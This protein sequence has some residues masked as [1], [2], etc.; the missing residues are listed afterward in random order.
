MQ[1][2]RLQ[3]REYKRRKMVRIERRLQRLPLRPVARRGRARGGGLGL[4]EGVGVPGGGVGGVRGVVGVL[5]GGRVGDG[6]A[7]G[8]FFGLGTAN[9]ERGRL[10]GVVYAIA[11]DGKKVT[12]E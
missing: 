10:A 6:E 11:E 7:E 2:M 12:G 1:L 8:F 5:V 4:G 9:R 3:N